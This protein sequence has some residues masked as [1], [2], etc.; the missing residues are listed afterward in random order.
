MKLDDAKLREAFNAIHKGELTRDDA[1]T[2]IDIAR[3]AASVDG[4]MDMAEMATVARLSKIVYAM[5]GEREEPVPSTPMA[6]GWLAG[7]RNKL[8][9]PGP[10]E[11][12]YA[13]ARVVILIDKKVTKEETELQRQLSEALRL[14]PKRAQELDRMIDTALGAASS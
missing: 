6:A 13:A 1:S 3:Y 11:L 5:S 8:T 9:A 10:R 7:I 4:R 2:I 12:A 14:D